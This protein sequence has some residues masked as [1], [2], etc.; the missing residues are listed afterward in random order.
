MG[1]GLGWALGAKPKRSTNSTR[2]TGCQESEDLASYP[3]SV[4]HIPSDLRSATHVP[5]VSVP[6][7]AKWEGKKK[8]FM[9]LITISILSLLL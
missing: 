4:A 1:H 3:A 9:D 2:P 6:S 8:S 7:H 5:Q